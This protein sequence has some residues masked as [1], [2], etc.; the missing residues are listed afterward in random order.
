MSLIMSFIFFFVINTARIPCF[1]PLSGRSRC[2]VITV[3][4]CV[5]GCVKPVHTPGFIWTVDRLSRQ[6][7]ERDSLRQLPSPS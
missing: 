1:L 4:G 6:R 3:A 7:Q 2:A 5:Q